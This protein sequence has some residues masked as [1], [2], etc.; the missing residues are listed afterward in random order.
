MKR[1]CFHK[2]ARKLHIFSK[3]RLTKQQRIARRK[4]RCEKRK[5]RRLHRKIRWERIKKKLEEKKD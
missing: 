4:A 3:G 2:R 5:Q 1:K